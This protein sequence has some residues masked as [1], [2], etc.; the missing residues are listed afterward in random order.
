NT[1]LYASLI[2][3]SPSNTLVRTATLYSKAYM[4]TPRFDSSHNFNHILSVTALS[5]E[6]FAKEQARR[7]QTGENLLNRQVVVLGALLHD[8]NDGK[9]GGHTL[10]QTSPG[11]LQSPPPGVSV[12]A[13]ADT[14][15]NA[16]AEGK[17]EGQADIFDLLV[18]WKCDEAFASRVSRLC[19]G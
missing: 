16:A 14:I 17:A 3:E 13:E 7:E 9:Y 18:S 2:S 1:S 10:S 5:L 12:F 4:S 8:I 6:I 15:G 19:S 11:G